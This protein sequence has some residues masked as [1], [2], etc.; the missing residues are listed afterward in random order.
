[1]QKNLS[2][3]EDLKC[4]SFFTYQGRTVTSEGGA[5]KDVGFW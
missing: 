2:K 5:H 1:M 4:T 3:K